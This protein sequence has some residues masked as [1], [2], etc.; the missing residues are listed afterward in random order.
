M[1]SG[2]YSEE[3]DADEYCQQYPGHRIS[4]FLYYMCLTEFSLFKEPDSLA[5]FKQ[6]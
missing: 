1:V 5:M 3:E 6:F 2:T 4:L